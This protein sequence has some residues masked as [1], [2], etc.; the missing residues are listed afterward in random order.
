MILGTVFI[1]NFYTTF[2]YENIS[3]NLSPKSYA[4][5]NENPS[6]IS[7]GAI[8]G[9]VIG[10]IL[11]IGLSIGGAY[12]YIRRSKKTPLYGQVYDEEKTT[13]GE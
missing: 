13:E 7:A 5:Y 12:F 10:S 8:W 9:M 11:L 6:G 3:I 4:S 1:Q 2:D